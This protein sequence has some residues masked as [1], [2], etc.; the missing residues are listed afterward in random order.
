MGGLRKKG[1]GG[2]KGGEWGPSF[3][4][5]GWGERR[6]MLTQKFLFFSSSVF[7]SLAI[8]QGKTDCS[9]MS[10]CFSVV[11][12]GQLRHPAEREF[13][14]PFF[15]LFFGRSRVVGGGGGVLKL[16]REAERDLSETLGIT[17]LLLLLFFFFFL[18]LF[19]SSLFYV[20]RKPRLLLL[21]L[22]LFLL[23]LLFFPKWLA[24]RKERD[25]NGV[26]FS[27]GDVWKKT[28]TMNN[29]NLELSSWEMKIT[30]IG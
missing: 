23:P 12:A 16:R 27:L 28:F 19:L 11:G 25:K 17:V 9:S 10:D 24:S 20:S 6:G 1:G 22:L 15:L 13:D 30:A 26:K 5:G 3:S 4:K 8:V 29:N 7:F 2:G 14:F 18:L 21:L